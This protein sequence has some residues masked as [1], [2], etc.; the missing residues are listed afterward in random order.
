MHIALVW[1]T[2]ESKIKVFQ[3][4]AMTHI[5]WPPLVFEN[6]KSRDVFIFDEDDDDLQKIY[7]H[8][9][10]YPRN[11][12]AV[13]NAIGSCRVTLL[14]SEKSQWIFSRLVLKISIFQSISMFFA[15]LRILIISTGCEKMEFF[16]NY[17]KQPP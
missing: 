8:S 3:K 13:W 6:L 12:N 2:Y 4:W 14:L 7:N 15:I 17:I 1:A 16:T 9:V 10:L 5:S 11:W